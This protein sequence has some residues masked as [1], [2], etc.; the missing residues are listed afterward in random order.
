[1][2]SFVFIMIITSISQI[3]PAIMPM[4]LLFEVDINAKGEY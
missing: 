1:M 4:I 2:L 3:L